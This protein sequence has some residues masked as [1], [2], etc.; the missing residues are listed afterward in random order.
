[1]PVDFVVGNNLFNGTLQY[2]QDKYVNI[3]DVLKTKASSNNQNSFCVIN[4]EKCQ[5]SFGTKVSSTIPP[6]QIQIELRKSILYITSYSL[7]SSINP[8][9]SSY[10]LKGWNLVA[11]IDGRKWEII[12][13]QVN[14]TVMNK[15]LAEANFK[16]AEGLFRFFRL[17]QTERGFTD[18]YGFAVRRIELF[19]TLYESNYVPNN[20]C[21]YKRQSSTFKHI[22]MFS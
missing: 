13:R 20:I 10:H 19:G 1:M 4:P 18:E 8:E 16:C 2:L 6:Q 9:N 21:T 5:Y 12:D 3:S 15:K 22:L 14:T 7:L 11:S 17:V